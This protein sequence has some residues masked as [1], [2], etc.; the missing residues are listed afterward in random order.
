MKMKKSVKYLLFAGIAGLI[1]GGSIILYMLNM[2]HRDVQGEKA[3]FTVEA[4]QFV[5]EFMDNEAESNT[6]YID[7][8]VIVSGT[9]LEISEDL[10]NQKVVLLKAEKSGVSC[11]FF[12]ESN[13]NVEKLSIGDK[14]KIK[15]KVNSGASYDEDMDLE[16]YANLEK[17]DIVK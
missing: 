14:V 10:L 5:N 4:N 8:I 2:P 15:G 3:A 11:T 16:E 9:V 17:C 7:Q 13:S 6:K 1:I 12:K